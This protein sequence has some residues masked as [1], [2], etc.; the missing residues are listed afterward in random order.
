MD[1]ITIYKLMKPHLDLLNWFVEFFR[2]SY[3]F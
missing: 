2:K 1:A 3:P